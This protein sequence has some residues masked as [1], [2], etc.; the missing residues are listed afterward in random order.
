MAGRT[1][2]DIRQGTVGGNT[3]PGHGPVTLMKRP[4]RK[5]TQGVVGAWG[6]KPRLPDWALA[7]RLGFN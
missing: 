2:I 1:G 5:R 6:E 3:L 7:T 4:V